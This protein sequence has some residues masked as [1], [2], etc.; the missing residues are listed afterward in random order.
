MILESTKSV[1]IS[2]AA[3]RERKSGL[4]EHR[5]SMLRR[6]P[7]IGDWGKFQH[8]SI[9]MKDIAYLTAYTGHEFAILRGKREDILVHG[10]ATR[11][12]FDDVLV[13]MLKAGK[14]RIYGHSHPGEEVPIPS[15]G[16][17]ETLRRIGQPDSRLISGYSG[18]E[19]VFSSDPFEIV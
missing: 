7:N 1:Q 19:V 14:L 6:V 8:E 4:N 10:E 2:L 18:I 16:D 17:R 12:R 9:S 13:D 5:E 3:I 11:C 15:N